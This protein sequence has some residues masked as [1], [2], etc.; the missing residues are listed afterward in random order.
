MKDILKCNMI[1]SFPR[2]YHDLYYGAENGYTF[3][4]WN[5]EVLR[6]A[7]N[8]FRDDMD[9]QNKFKGDMLEVF[10]E[11]FFALYHADP[12]FGLQHDYEPVDISDDFGVDSRATNVAGHKSVVQIK[13]RSNPD[14]VIS[15]ADIARTYT[16]ALCQFH[17]EDVFKHD[18]TVFL[19]TNAGGVTGAFTTVMQRKTVILTMGFIASKVDNNDSFWKEAYQ[20]IFRTLDV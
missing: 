18:R 19:F 15:Y 3:R 14:E 7:R 20:L 2:E 4:E 10:A 16:S 17:I 12:E 8:L 5:N 11:I 9:A 6:V 13:Y 1:H